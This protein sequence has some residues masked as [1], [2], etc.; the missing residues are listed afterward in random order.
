[1]QLQITIP[2]EE[3]ERLTRL[4]KAD[5]CASVEEYVQ[6]IASP[7][8][9]A[10]RVKPSTSDSDVDWSTPVEELTREQWRRR[11]EDFIS[12]QRSWNPDFDDSR[13]SIYD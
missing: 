11:F 3:V 1:M 8:R 5:G 9:S 13:D 6:K 10:S 4:A 7:D 12:Q 2:D